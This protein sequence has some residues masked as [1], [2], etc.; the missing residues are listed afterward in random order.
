MKVCGL[1]LIIGNYTANVSS[2]KELKAVWVSKEKILPVRFILKGIESFLVF[3][4]C[5]Q[6]KKL[7]FI[8]KGIESLEPHANDNAH[9]VAVSSSKEL[10]VD[11]S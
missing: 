2:S 10:K 8:L 5:T 11:Q 6:A 4:L 1:P 9:I 3:L 7:H